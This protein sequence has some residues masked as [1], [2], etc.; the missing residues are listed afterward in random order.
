MDILIATAHILGTIIASIVFG[1]V[2]MVV[3][4]SVNNKM[5]NQGKEDISVRLGISIEDLDKEVHAPK[6]VI[7]S[8]EK[9]NSE[10]FRNRFSDF[11]GL[12]LL[13]FVWLSLLVLAIALIAVLW[14]TI[15]DNTENAVYAWF[16]LGI[17]ILRLLTIIIFSYICKFLTGRIPGEAKAARKVVAECIKDSSALRVAPHE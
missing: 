4:V 14:F 1:C 10:L 17:Y 8:S 13:A 12:V 15:T 6:L 5:L 2:E 9:Y 7:L 3:S 11:C 16:L